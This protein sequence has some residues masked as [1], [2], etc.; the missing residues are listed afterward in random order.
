[1][2]PL[3]RRRREPNRTHKGTR[4]TIEALGTGWRHRSTGAF[5]TNNRGGNALLGTTPALIERGIPAAA[6]QPIAGD[7]MAVAKS[8]RDDVPNCP[9]WTLVWRSSE[10]DRRCVVCGVRATQEPFIL[11]GT[12]R[13]RTPS[14][15]AD[16]GERTHFHL[17]VAVVVVLIP[18]VSEHGPQ[19]AAQERDRN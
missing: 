13:G 7:D 4:R 6:F 10:T 14:V 12:G 19:V 8:P 1:V 16:A 15:R 11:P 9:M 3:L 17:G 5:L 2:F 18:V